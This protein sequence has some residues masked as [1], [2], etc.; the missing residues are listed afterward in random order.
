MSNR[1]NKSARFIGRFCFWGYFLRFRLSLDPASAGAIFVFPPVP[2]PVLAVP[3]Y[4]VSVFLPVP[5]RVS[6]VPVVAVNVVFPAP[7]PVPGVLAC[8]VPI[9]PVVFWSFCV[10]FHLQIPRG[11]G[12]KDDRLPAARCASSYQFPPSLQLHEPTLPTF[13]AGEDASSFY[14]Q[15]PPGELSYCS[16]GGVWRLRLFLFCEIDRV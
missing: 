14:P 15:F 4:A 12:G 9:L 8:A 11:K 5:V 1:C 3:V 7:L 16:S 2:A 13:A 6:G 10:F